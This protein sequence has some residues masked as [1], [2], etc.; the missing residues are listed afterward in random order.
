MQLK[1]I[2]TKL[3]ITLYVGDVASGLIGDQFCDMLWPLVSLGLQ[4][5]QEG[6]MMKRIIVGR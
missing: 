2:Y 5:Q 3:W 1:G 4:I 6:R